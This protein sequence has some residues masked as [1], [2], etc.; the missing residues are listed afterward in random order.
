MNRF[1]HNIKP[2]H[3]EYEQSLVELYLSLLYISTY[4][5]GLRH[6]LRQL[7]AHRPQLLKPSV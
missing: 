5:A 3:K 6:G 7:H 4:S 1:Y 2:V